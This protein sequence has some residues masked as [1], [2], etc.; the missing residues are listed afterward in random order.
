M[1]ALTELVDIG[2]NLENQAIKAWKEE[3]RKIVGFF[4]S[5]VP[6]EI[7][8]AA[9]ILPVRVRATGCE[10]TTSADVYFSQ[11]NCSFMRSCLEFALEGKY[12]FLDGI[13]FT[14]SCDHVRRTY[15]TLRET[16]SDKFPFL[17]FISV[18]HK[19]S[20]QSISF[21]RDELVRFREKVEGFSGVK[22]TRKNLKRAIDVYNETRGLLRKVYELRQ[23]SS[24]PVT[25][26]QSVSMI[27]GGLSVPK[28]QYNRLLGRLLEE[29]SE[30][31]GISDY[32]ARLMLSGAGG[33]E[34]P[35]YYQIIEDLGGLIVTDSL[36]FGSRYFWEP[37]KMDGDLILSLAIS[38]INRPSCASMG[39]RVA[40]RTDYVK[41]M[42]E[43]FNVEGVIYQRMRYCDLWGGQILHLRQSLEEANIPLLELERE[44][45]VGAAG[46]L[47]TRVQAFLERI[48]R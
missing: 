33:C 43:E 3:G 32:R 26:A 29:I 22:V 12:K 15:D 13:V 36:C 41:R 9:D 2:R 40:E 30:G 46:Q 11:Y 1:S 20:E 44:Y 14:N 19:T 24:P 28:D 25:G 38:Y 17:E 8:Y 34:D 35:A 45:I 10:R 27:T 6:E 48:E 42:V 7:L 5:Y 37:V 16:C 23:G 39:D 18:P 47:K 31:E 4:C 21:Y